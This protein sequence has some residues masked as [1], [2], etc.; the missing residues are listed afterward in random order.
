MKP[1]NAYSR[2][3]DLYSIPTS[4]IPDDLLTRWAASWRAR[5]KPRKATDDPKERE[6]L[7]KQAERMRNRRAAGKA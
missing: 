4:E 3:W 5:R 7:D 2:D 1:Q 6:R